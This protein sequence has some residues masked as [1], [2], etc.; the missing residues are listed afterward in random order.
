M[1]F[2]A[3]ARALLHG[4]FAKSFAKVASKQLGTLKRQAIIRYTLPPLYKHGTSLPSPTVA[5]KVGII[6]SS[7]SEVVTASMFWKAAR[8]SRLF[9]S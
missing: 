4:A 5:S 1:D 8:F 2:L 9:D 3:L 7:T 6:S